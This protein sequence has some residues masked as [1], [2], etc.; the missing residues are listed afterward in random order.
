MGKSE[1]A[2]FGRSLRELR[3]ARGLSQEELA[4]RAGIHPKFLGEIERAQSDLKLR[5]IIK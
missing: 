2:E 4:D 1:T 5:S 3:K